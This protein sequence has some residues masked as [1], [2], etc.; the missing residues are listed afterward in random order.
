MASKNFPQVPGWSQADQR[1]VA[2]WYD[3]HKSP[4]TPNGRPWWSWVERPAEGAGMPMPVG[5]LQPGH[6]DQAGMNWQ[7][8]WVPE[9]QYIIKG[10]G[11]ASPGATVSEHRFKIDYVA[12]IGDRKNAMK[13]YYNRAVIESLGQ[14]WD[15]PDYGGAISFKLR[16]IIGNPPQSQKIPEAALAED[17]W[18]LGFSTVE[19]STLARLLE[20]G[21]ED[22]PTATQ[23]EAKVDK[24][25]GIEAK[26]AEQAALIEKLL[27]G[28]TKKSADTDR[29]AKVR[30]ARKPKEPQTAA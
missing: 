11:R 1:S 6:P 22:T 9:Q 20:S 8:P 5:E 19:N 18:L 4:K 23:S 3:Q 2:I 17:P 12:M 7:A 28:Q 21:R 27:A 14:G 26:L 25:A 15:A 13:E 24:M 16:Q 10:I 29:M 30:A